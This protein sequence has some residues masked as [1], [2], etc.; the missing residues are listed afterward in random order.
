MAK[1]SDT[2]LIVLAAAAG[3]DDG[4]AVIPAT[5]KAGIVTKVGS[6]LVDRKLMREVRTKADMPVWYADETGS[7]S[8]ARHYRSR[9]QDHWRR[10][11]GRQRRGHGRRSDDTDCWSEELRESE[12][13][14]RESRC[15]NT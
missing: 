12:D 2:Q 13:N 6:S 15:I 3:H 4:Y 5:M 9:P 11:E 1:L 7:E 8:N 14:G 10:G